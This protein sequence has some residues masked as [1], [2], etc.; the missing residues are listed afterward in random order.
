[1]KKHGEGNSVEKKL[2]WE[3]IAVRVLN[4]YLQHYCTKYQRGSVTASLLHGLFWC[5]HPTL[6]VGR[7]AGWFILFLIRSEKWEI[8]CEGQSH[9]MLH[10]RSLRPRETLLLWGGAL[11]DDKKLWRLCSRRTKSQLCVKQMCLP[12]IISHN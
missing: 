11:R 10:S 9:G 3:N 2:Q 8:T 5:R 7:L 12:S 4:I 1:M 6:L